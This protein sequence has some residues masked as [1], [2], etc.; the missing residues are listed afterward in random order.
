MRPKSCPGASVGLY[1]FHWLLDTSRVAVFTW[2]YFVHWVL[3]G[4]RKRIRGKRREREELKLGYGRL[5]GPG[6]LFWCNIVCKC[7]RML[8][9]STSTGRQ[10]T[11]GAP[12]RLHPWFGLLRPEIH[13]DWRCPVSFRTHTL[14][15][16]NLQELTATHR[17]MF[18]RLLPFARPWI[19][20]C[21]AS[22]S[23]RSGEWLV[24]R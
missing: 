9:L 8:L 16:T 6:W 5:R 7:C 23:S 24:A 21:P 3:L 4:L 15:Q 12:D 13:L 14:S 17:R 22:C 2:I 20:T 1:S 10:G 18:R 11:G 19:S